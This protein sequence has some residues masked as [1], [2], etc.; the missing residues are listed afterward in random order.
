MELL[1]ALED[2]LFPLRCPI[3]YFSHQ[4]DLVAPGMPS[5][6]HTVATAAT[7]IDKASTLTLGSPIHLY[8]PHAVSTVLQVRRTQHFST[9]Q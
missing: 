3:A 8:A 1:Q 9:W 5:C 4:L 7:L 2:N 6:L